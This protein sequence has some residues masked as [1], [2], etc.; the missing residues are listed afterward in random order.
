MFKLRLTAMLA[1]SV[2]LLSVSC[3]SAPEKQDDSA[4]NAQSAQKARDAADR[5]FMDET[6]EGIG[7]EDIPRSLPSSSAV[8]NQE[9]PEFV[10]VNEQ[11]KDDVPSISSFDEPS[12]M[13]AMADTAQGEQPEWVKSPQK[14]FSQS[15]YL[16]AVGMGKNTVDA[17]NSAIASIGKII[18]QNVSSK[19]VTTEKDAVSSSGFSSSSS[20]LDEIIETYSV[21][22]ALVGVKIHE[23]WW[24]ND[25]YVYALAYLNKAEAAQYYSRKI[26]EN[27]S[28]IDDR[29]SFA[30]SRKGSFDAFAAVQ[31]AVRA[32][33]ENNQ[34]MDIL[35]AVQP[36]AYRAKKLS[37]G[38]EERVKEAAYDAAMA[39]S[40]DVSVKGTDDSRIA[41][42]V[43]LMLSS[44]GFRT[45]LADEK[46]TAPYIIEADVEFMDVPS[47]RN[48]Y[49]RYVFNAALKEVSS[50]KILLPYSEN[51]RE[52][53]TSASEA[54]QKALRTLEKSIVENYAQA[55]V[56]Y[57]KTSQ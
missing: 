39:I 51:K 17:E 26:S 7:D 15:Q 9:E 49:V 16:S 34:Y 31:K 10:Y 24:G 56:N 42:A 45:K 19:V 18:K 4:K 11:G 35:N 50:G 57:L 33:E 32:A 5:A 14:A 21:V 23:F 8:T 47:E 3:K 37:Y 38:S 55:F 36:S 30:N 13:F 46:S 1:A 27:E 28:L 2:L 44:Y 25:G 52:G 20:T 41:N 22:D 48:K 6:G 53:H 29:L 54:Q 40:I 43:I 12:V